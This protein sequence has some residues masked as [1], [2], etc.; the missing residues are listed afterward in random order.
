MRVSRGIPEFSAT[1]YDGGW[2][3]ATLRFGACVLDVD[4]R[5]LI[6][7]GQPV[8][9]SP[10]A[11]DLLSLLVTERRRAVPKAELHE[12]IWPGTFVTDDSLI[13]LVREVRAAIGDH[14]RPARFLRTV[15]GFGYGFEN[16]VEDSTQLPAACYLV[17][18]G[19]AVPLFEGGNLIGRELA[20]RIMLDSM[21]V[22]HRHARMTVQDG[23]TTLEDLG[24][25]NGTWLNGQRINGPVTLSHGDVVTI[26]GVALTYHAR[27]VPIDTKDDSQ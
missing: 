20:A 12:R 9:L 21:R 5:Q 8:H 26:G 19:R 13:G 3:M 25:R 14:G 15:H 27:G 16:V 7:G 11:F 1:S 4:R 17:F 24:S 18:S 2:T 22:S 23:C 6:R 10:K